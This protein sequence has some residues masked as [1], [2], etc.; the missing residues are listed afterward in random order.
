MLTQL[1]DTFNFSNPLKKRYFISPPKFQSALP[2]PQRLVR[3]ALA[4][5]RTYMNQGL[6]EQYEIQPPGGFEPPGGFILSG[7]SNGEI[8]RLYYA[9]VL[10]STS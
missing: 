5:K 8:C 1:P 3:L 4:F 10:L 2:A 6:S 9:I 7:D